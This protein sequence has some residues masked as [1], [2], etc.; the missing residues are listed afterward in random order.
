MQT[1]KSTLYVLDSSV[2]IDLN[3]LYPRD[4]FPTLW[5]RLLVAANGGLLI[6]TDA[7]WLELQ[8]QPDDL[9]RRLRE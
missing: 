3:R 6:S 1:E 5:D 8:Q 4:I 9:L 7:I 2:F